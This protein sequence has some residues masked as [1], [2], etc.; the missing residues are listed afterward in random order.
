MVAATAAAMG[1]IDV[2][3]NYGGI[4]GPTVPVE[5]MDPEAWEMV[6]KVAIPHL[7]K[8]N[9]RVIL[10]MSSVAGRFG[11][12]NR[13]PYCTATWSLIGFT[14]PCQLNLAGTESA[15]KRYFPERSSIRTLEWRRANVSA[16]AS[17]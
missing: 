4:P 2:L 3:V 5:L 7:K 11:Y 15:Q 8:S 12:A 6:M 17:K 16:M 9:A 1:G 10:N 14:K 13:S